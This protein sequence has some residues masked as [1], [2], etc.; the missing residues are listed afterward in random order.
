[1]HLFEINHE[2]ETPIG[3]GM[4]GEK[5]K[6]RNGR[7]GHNRRMRKKAALGSEIL[8]TWVTM[9]LRVKKCVRQAMRDIALGKGTETR[10][11]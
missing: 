4:L 10:K 3:K 5:G 2:E 11:R 8:I 1:M 7:E 9:V 6:L